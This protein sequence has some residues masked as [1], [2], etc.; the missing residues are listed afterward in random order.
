MHRFVFAAIC[1]TTWSQPLLAQRASRAGGAAFTLEWGGAA[2]G[3]LIGAA[4]AHVIL[5]QSRGACGSE[6]LRCLLG[7]LGAIGA[8]SAVGAATG[9]YLAGRA[10]NTHPSGWGSF[11]GAVVGIG[12]GAAAVKGL[13][14]MGVRGRLAVALSYAAVQGLVTAAGSRVIR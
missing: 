3:S 12:A 4:A 9:G 8:A 11:L 7:R 5:T 1:L 10:A 14:E 2:A 13:D 6:D